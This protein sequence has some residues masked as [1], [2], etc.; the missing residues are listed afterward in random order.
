MAWQELCK[1]VWAIAMCCCTR[2]MCCCRVQGPATSLAYEPAEANV[3]ARAPRD[4][5]TERLVSLPLLV[6]SYIIMGLAESLCCF[7]AYLWV[8]DKRGVPASEI[9]L[10]NPKDN[11]W[12]SQADQIDAPVTVDGNLFSEEQ[13]Q[14]IV[15]QVRGRLH[16]ACR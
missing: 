3:M 14:D 5:A 11:T 12:L 9:F 2:C 15:R 16:H 8:F 1:G 10:L 7:G 4:I 13:Q 6:Y